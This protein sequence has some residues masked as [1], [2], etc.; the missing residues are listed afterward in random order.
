M[1]YVDDLRPVRRAAGCFGTRVSHSCHMFADNRDELHAFAKKIGLKKA[2]FHYRGATSH[3]D[4][5]VTKRQL[6]MAQGAAEVGTKSILRT[7]RRRVRCDHP[8]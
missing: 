6:A 7:L 5:T 3:Y 1:I 8:A 2:Y 4:L